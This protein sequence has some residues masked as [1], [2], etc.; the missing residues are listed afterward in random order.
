MV[1]LFIDSSQSTWGPHFSGQSHLILMWWFPEMGVTPPNHPFVVVGFSLINQ[2]LLGVP[3]WIGNPHIP[4]IS[5]YIPIFPIFM[6][7][8]ISLSFFIHVSEHLEACHPCCQAG[9]RAEAATALGCQAAVH[10]GAVGSTFWLQREVKQWDDPKN[11]DV[12]GE[13]MGK[14]CD[15]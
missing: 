8:S 2:P 9:V 5:Q 12:H 4:N 11:G 1:S 15:I 10:L 13:S 14:C 3:P 6:E 7:L